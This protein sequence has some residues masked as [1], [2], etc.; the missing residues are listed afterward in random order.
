MSLVQ[1]TRTLSGSG[2]IEEE[3]HQMVL[4]HPLHR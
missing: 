3:E 4:W 2:P 1:Q